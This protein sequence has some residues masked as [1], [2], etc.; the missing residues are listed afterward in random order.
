MD[1]MTTN[2]T[3]AFPVQAS[4]QIDAFGKLYNAKKQGE[5]T[6]MQAKAA[7]QATQTAIITGVA[8]LYFWSADARRT[9]CNH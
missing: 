5:L 4:W 9:A 6:V 8:N 1:G 7:R 2:E 3:Y